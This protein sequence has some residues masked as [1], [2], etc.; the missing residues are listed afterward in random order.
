MIAFQNFGLRVAK[1]FKNTGIHEVSSTN[2]M[3][4]PV[5][6]LPLVMRRFVREVAE[7][8]GCDSTYVILPMLASLARAVGNKRVVQLSADWTEPCVV[9]ALVIGQSGTR[10]SPAFGHAT[11]F[12]QEVHNAEQRRHRKRLAQYEKKHAAWK[13]SKAS[14]ASPVPPRHETY[15]VNHTTF[16]ALV[17]ALHQQC[18]TSV[19][20]KSDEL[21]GLLNSFGEYRGRRDATASQWLSFFRAESID[22]KRM[23]GPIQEAHIARA[24]VSIVGTIQPAI[25]KQAIGPQHIENGLCSRFLLAMPADRHKRWSADQIVPAAAKLKMKV[26]FD[27]LLKLPSG[28]GKKAR[29]IKPI[30]LSLSPLAQKLWENFVND[31]RE[32]LDREPNGA[33][34]AALSKLEAYAARLA[35]IFQLVSWSIGER[36]KN[37]Q[38]YRNDRV[39]SQSLHRAIRWT[40]WF[41]QETRRVY[42]YFAESTEDREERELIELIRR[43]DPSSLPSITPSKLHRNS[44][45]YPSVADAE[46]ALERLKEKQLGYW[47]TKHPGDQGGRPSRRFVL[48]RKPM[49][50]D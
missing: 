22:W 27:K 5:K 36:H 2:T 6:S 50:T 33:L 47:F 15:I 29:H 9:W 38:A 1:T 49:Q 20:C 23:R 10:K 45:A 3:A 11:S 37:G 39:E 14:T 26:V 48:G 19:L 44:R 35:L 24:N 42:A 4:L 41:A 46:L 13:K 17:Q 28:E 18:D 30:Q 31:W 12:L 43:L 32:Q 21:A 34:R 16:P 40:K 8:I 25:F 7:S